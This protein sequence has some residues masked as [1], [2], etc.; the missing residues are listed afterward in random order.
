M[1]RLMLALAGLAAVA[2]CS[3][4]TDE[5]IVSGDSYARPLEEAPAE[6]TAPPTHANVGAKLTPPRRQLRQRHPRPEAAE[7][8]PIPS[9][10]PGPDTAKPI[11]SHAE[12][13]WSPARESGRSLPA[14]TTIGAV[15]DDSINSRNDT[16]GEPVMAKIVADITDRL[17][18]V[19]VPAES[20]VQLSIIELEP[21]KS[22]TAA[23]GKLALRVDSIFVEGRAYPISADVQVVPHE[24]QGRGVSAGEV[25]KVGVGTAVGAVVGRVI[26][27]TVRGAVIGG[28]IGAAGGTAVAAQTAS[29]DVVVKPGTRV[30]FVLRERVAVKE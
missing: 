28:V 9:R 29:R 22:R 21:A 7:S 27:G 10:S 23:D 2:A 18:E 16:A 8:T 5:E 20:P 14:G 1:T 26:T 12:P 25:E 13:A 3:R 6:S 24:L 4:H 11:P 30:T 15:L 17:G 19:I